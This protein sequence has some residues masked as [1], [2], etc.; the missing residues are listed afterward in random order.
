[1]NVRKSNGIKIIQYL[2]SVWPQMANLESS[3]SVGQELIA[4][5]KYVLFESKSKN[6]HLKMWNMNSKEIIFIFVS[7]FVLDG[8]PWSCKFTNRYQWCSMTSSSSNEMDYRT[9]LSEQFYHVQWGTFTVVV[10]HPNTIS[11]VIPR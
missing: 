4:D 3:F 10:L 11:I 2:N 9:E 1:M 5:P 7:F 8:Q 6:S